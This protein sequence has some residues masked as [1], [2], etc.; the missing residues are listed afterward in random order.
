M[1]HLR[2]VHC[3][4]AEVNEATLKC[5]SS[6]KTQYWHVFRY[7]LFVSWGFNCWIWL[8]FANQFNQ[9]TI[10]YVIVYVGANKHW[11]V[12]YMPLCFLCQNT[13]LSLCLWINSA[14]YK[15]LYLGKTWIVFHQNSEDIPPCWKILAVKQWF[16]T[17]TEQNDILT[18]SY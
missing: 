14:F 17:A 2:R 9:P 3:S 15:A 12:C 5:I 4:D 18:R 11:N 1:F 16:A 6:A 10:T 8:K 13:I 7:F